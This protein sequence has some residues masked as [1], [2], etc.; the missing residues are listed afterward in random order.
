LAIAALIACE[1]KVKKAVAITTTPGMAKIHQV[2]LM[3]Y[4]NDSSHL[5]IA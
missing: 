2:M 3:R 4:A 5:E 1:L